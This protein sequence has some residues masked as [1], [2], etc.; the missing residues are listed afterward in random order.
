MAISNYEQMKR[1]MQVHF[2]DYDQE[3]MIRRFSLKSDDSFLYL[4]FL[5]R[6]YRVDR[7]SGRVEWS[8]NG[9]VDAVEADYNEAMSIFD[10][11]CCSQEDCC[12]S[13]EFVSVNNL[14]GI[15]AGARSGNGM[16]SESAEFFDGKTE[17]LR[18]ACKQM[19]GTEI[20]QGDVGFR[21]WAFDF[22]PF[23][24]R[25]WEADEEFPPSLSLLWDRNLLKYIHYETSYF[26]AG[27]LMRRLKELMEEDKCFSEHRD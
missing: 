1:Q 11:L 14:P 2:L 3:K 21:L 24:L 6:P 4:N 10:V 27:H 17:A 15:V 9:F 18:I 13:G 16:F 7:V 19:G 25:F 23:E 12:L 26:I 8:E 20:P 5:G 22:L